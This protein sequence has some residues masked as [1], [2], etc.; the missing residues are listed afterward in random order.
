MLEREEVKGTAP[1]KLE[2]NRAEKREDEANMLVA[3]IT[4]ALKEAETFV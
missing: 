2:R 3:G 1:V 4:K